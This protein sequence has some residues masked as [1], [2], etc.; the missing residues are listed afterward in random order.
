MTTLQG[1]KQLMDFDRV[2]GPGTSQEAVFE[3]TRPIVMSCVDGTDA[4]ILPIVT[5]SIRQ[6]A[7]L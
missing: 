3:D 2:Y 7:H 1:D 4:N 6:T 5:C